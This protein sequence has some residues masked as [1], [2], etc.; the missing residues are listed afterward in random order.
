MLSPPRVPANVRLDK[1]D[2]ALF[3]REQFAAVAAAV[4]AQARPINPKA[5]EDRPMCTQCMVM[6]PLAAA[7]ASGPT[8]SPAVWGG[9]LDISEMTIKFFCLLTQSFKSEMSRHL[10]HAERGK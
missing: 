8:A 3:R 5:T 9:M 10:A 4:L 6:T 1:L 7:A 2:S